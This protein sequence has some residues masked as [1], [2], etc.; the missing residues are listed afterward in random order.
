MLVSLTPTVDD[1]GGSGEGAF[2]DFHTQ[3]GAQ[4]DPA[5]LEGWPTTPGQS[6]A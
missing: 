5:W 6:Q 3:C 4:K 2:P 1:P